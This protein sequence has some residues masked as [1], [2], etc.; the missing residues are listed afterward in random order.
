MGELDV[1]PNRVNPMERYISR[2]IAS[3]VPASAALRAGRRIDDRTVRVSQPDELA[4]GGLGAM[5]IRGGS[6]CFI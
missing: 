2:I 3:M 6:R 4:E 1:G 5:P